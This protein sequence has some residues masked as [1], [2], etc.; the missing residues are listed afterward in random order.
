[1]A[2]LRLLMKTTARLHVY[3]A[4]PAPE[5]AAWAQSGKLTLHARPLARGG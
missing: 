2:K 5:I 1:M 4:N 3:A